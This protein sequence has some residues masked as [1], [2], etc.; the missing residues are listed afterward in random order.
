MKLKF[1]VCKFCIY[2]EVIY[3]IYIY[4]LF[5]YLLLLFLYFVEEYCGFFKKFEMLR[6]DNS[7][8]VF[9]EERVVFMFSFLFNI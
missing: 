7:K 8:E 3:F 6:E 2:W 5:F 9:N 1:F 4:V